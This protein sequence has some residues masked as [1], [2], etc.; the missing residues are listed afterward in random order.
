[1][2]PGKRTTRSRVCAGQPV[3]ACGPGIRVPPARSTGAGESF[4]GKEREQEYIPQRVMRFCPRCASGEF[5]FRQNNSFECRSCG[6]QFFMNAAAAVVAL[7]E[8]DAGRLLLAR[9]A[10]DPGK[11]MLDLPGGFADAGE[12]AEQALARE[13]KEELNLE[14]EQC[15]Y[16][17]S[18]PNTYLYGG[19]VYNTMDLAFTCTVKDLGVIKADDDVGGYLF[20]KPD[21]IPLEEM[22]FDSIRRVAERYRDMRVEKAG[23]G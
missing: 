17:C 23:R 3:R 6:F 22:S 8:D 1:V 13:V 19:I 12:T 5:L 11:G 15:T 21:E 16:F 7:I 9:R 2:R 20:L 14:I 18:F 4:M 10:R